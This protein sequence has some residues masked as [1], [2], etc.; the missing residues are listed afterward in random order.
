MDDFVMN[1]Y[2]WRIRKVPSFSDFLVDRT[3]ELTVATTDP[4]TL[5]IYISDKLTGEFKSRVVVHELAHAVMFSYYLVDDLH[6][7]V[8]PE[9]WFEAEE[10]LCNLIADYGWK[11]FEVYNKLKI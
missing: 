11:I 1:G 2:R 10:M 9:H 3:G 6:S 4:S 5:E 8:S 7:V